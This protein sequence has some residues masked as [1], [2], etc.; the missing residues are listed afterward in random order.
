MIYLQAACGE[1][2]RPESGDRGQPRQR[3]GDDGG[4]QAEHHG[5]AQHDLRGVRQSLQ[6]PGN[7][8]L[9]NGQ[10]DKNRDQRTGILHIVRDP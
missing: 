7:T 8:P 10:N 9:L 4:V 1:W 3:Q 6:A 5:A 2:L